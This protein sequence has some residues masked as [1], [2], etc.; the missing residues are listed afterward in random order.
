MKWFYWIENHCSRVERGTFPEKHFCL[1]NYLLPWA[2]S[3]LYV[4]DCLI[5]IGLWSGWTTALASIDSCFWS[6]QFV[7]R[8]AENTVLSRKMVCPQLP[9]GVWGVPIYMTVQGIRQNSHF[10]KTFPL[11]TSIT[12]MLS[13]AGGGFHRQG[14]RRWSLKI[15]TERNSKFTTLCTNVFIQVAEQILAF[16]SHIRCIADSLFLLGE[17]QDSGACQVLL[18]WPRSFDQLL[19][20]FFFFQM[21]FVPSK[22]SLW[23]GV[24]I[25]CWESW[26]LGC[27]LVKC[28]SVFGLR[29]LASITAPGR[30]PA[31]YCYKSI[32]RGTLYLTYSCPCLSH[33]V[34]V[35]LFFLPLSPSFPAHSSPRISAP[36]KEV[37]SSLIASEKNSIELRQHISPCLLKT[38]RSWRENCV[39]IFLPALALIT[40]LSGP[41]AD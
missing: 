22:A 24:I 37:Y 8:A 27:H 19:K 35:T 4:I 28:N 5:W 11:L 33:R 29:P 6:R 26:D 20:V 3:S 31:T 32:W 38:L 34:G 2:C 10:P 15:Q 30:A 16:A 25:L 1:F 36:D 18:R 40:P 39:F 12:K 13:P 14:G 7:F 17:P 23:D 41:G 9:W 21:R